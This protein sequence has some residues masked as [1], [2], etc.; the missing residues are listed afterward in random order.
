MKPTPT[1]LTI[2]LLFTALSLWFWGILSPSILQFY[3]SV[4]YFP[5]TPARVAEAFSRPGGLAEYLS[6]F[7]VQ[8]FCWKPVAASIVT[9][10]L[11]AIQYLTWDLMKQHGTE[12]YTYGLSFIPAFC[13]WAYLCVSGNLFTT[14]VSLTITLSAL[15]LYHKYIAGRALPLALITAVLYYIC[16]PISILIPLSV[17]LLDIRKPLVTIP[18]ILIWALIPLALSR[19]LHYP[20]RDLYLGINYI[21]VP[22]NYPATLFIMAFSPFASLLPASI[23]LPSMKNK[24]AIVLTITLTLLVFIGGWFFVVRNCNPVNE[25]ILKYDKLIQEEKW[26]E[27][28]E[29]ASKRPPR[30]VAEV[31]AIDLA[32]AMKGSLLDKMLMYPQPGATALFP[33]YN[34]G[35]VMSLTTDEAMFRCGMLNSA[36]HYAYEKFESYPDY[37][38]GARYLKRLAQIDMINGD[39]GTAEKYLDCLSHTLVHA[40]WA[41]G[42]KTALDSGQFSDIAIC[43][44]TSEY[45]YN[46]T[47]DDEKRLMLR[48]MAES[49]HY[50]SVTIQYLLAFDLLLGDLDSLE[51]DLEYLDTSSGVPVLVVQALTICDRMPGG[52]PQFLESLITKADRT[53]Y[54]EYLETAAGGDTDRLWQKYG[55]TYWYY[56]HNM[57]K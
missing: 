6:E 42:L 57:A 27:I 52:L 53:A 39:A 18:A 31:S 26:D 43:C 20:I 16:G 10:F 44:D 8:F 37:K 3:E 34:L 25:R 49:G 7:F 15:Y 5:L 55:R 24:P 54:S 4:L 1:H 41:A 45:L 23:N 46:D 30:T 29:T 56:H 47:E 17:L 40:R 21:N 11:L 48:R 9:L 51:S 33:D 50:N 12:E 36:R 35:Y 38:L 32:L 2:T 19:F 13:A 22:G 28:T 14:I